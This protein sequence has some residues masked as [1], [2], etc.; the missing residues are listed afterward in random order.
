M[1]IITKVM[2]KSWKFVG[3]NVYEPCIY[4]HNKFY[5]PSLSVLT[6][7]IK[8]EGNFFSFQRQ[9]IAR[10]KKEASRFKKLKVNCLDVFIFHD[11]VSFI[12]PVKKQL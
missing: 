10:L 4:N 12:E 6:T 2:E 8:A 5:P 9:N 11:T 7:K 3:K 1:E